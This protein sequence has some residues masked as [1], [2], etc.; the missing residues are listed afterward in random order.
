LSNWNQ[1]LSSDNSKILGIINLSNDS[2]TGDGV[3][4][5][6]EKLNKLLQ[7]AKQKNINF[8]DVGCASTKPGFVNITTKE[9]IER[10]N[11]FINTNQNKFSFSI[12]SF[13]PIVAKHAVENYFEIINDVSGFMDEEMVRIAIESRSKIILV[14]RHPKSE[15]LHHKMIYKNVVKEVKQHLNLKIK[16][17]LNL[18]VKEEQIAIDPGLGFGKNLT[19]SVELLLNIKELKEN[20]PLIVGYSKKKFIKKIP[21]SNHDLFKYCVDSGVSLVRLHLTN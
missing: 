8:I 4:D 14:H 12:D 19:D 13:N 2:F 15:S 10:L 11:Y 18:G 17:L 20:F 5:N 6:D 9:E 16:S 21:M 7:S 1:V 3:F